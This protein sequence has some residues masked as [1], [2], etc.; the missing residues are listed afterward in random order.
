MSKTANPHFV[1]L[2]LAACVLVAPLAGAVTRAE[3]YQATVPRAD[4]SEAGQDSAFVAGLKIVMVRVTGRRSAGE[5]AVFAPLMS[6]A[7]RYVQQYRVASDNLLWI[8]FDG[9]AID[10]WLAQ[11]GQPIWGRDRPTTFIWLAMPAAGSAGASVAKSDDTSALKSEIEA[12][13]QV[14]GVP[15]RWPT[16][17]ELQPRRIDYAAILNGPTGT[18]VDL[19]LRLG[20]EAV[21]I[22]R[23]V[24]A[25]GV[26]SWRWSHQFQDRSS[27]FSGTIEGIDGAADLYA[28]LFAASGAPTPVDIEIAGLNDVT[29]YAKVQGLLES[30]AFVSHVSVRSLNADRAQFR[31]TVRG[32]ARALQRALSLNASLEALPA[33]DTSFL[34]FHLRQ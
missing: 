23:P 13:A 25:N 33:T 21:L 27:E 2:F 28:G 20:A 32:G 10:R 7:R 17:A 9:N 4:R 34:R 31:V 22:G 6:D 26:V 30:L 8:S 1:R 18:L 5:E 3:L 15:V 14:R 16:A 11:N 12:E 19:G 29:A 24:T